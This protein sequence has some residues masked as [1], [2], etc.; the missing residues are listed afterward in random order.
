M[1]KNYDAFLRN[2][3]TRYRG[4]EPRNERVTKIATFAFPPTN[5]YC[6][7]STHHP[8]SRQRHQKVVPF[9]SSQSREVAMAVLALLP[10]HISTF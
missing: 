3:S 4:N 5:A 10:F 6:L 7:P 2:S 9:I 8:T 1:V